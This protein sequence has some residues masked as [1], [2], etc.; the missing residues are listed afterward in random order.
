MFFKIGLTKLLLQI[1]IGSI[2]LAIIEVVFLYSEIF[3]LELQMLTFLRFL[4]KSRLL[5]NNVFILA[6]HVQS[7]KM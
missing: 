6:I 1:L 5:I 7:Y 3:S 2:Y 4:N